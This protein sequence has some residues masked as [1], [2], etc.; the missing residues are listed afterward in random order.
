MTPADLATKQPA[1]IVATQPRPLL[2]DGGR[3]VLPFVFLGLPLLFIAMFAFAFMA[4]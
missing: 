3:W 4:A 2:P 1:Q